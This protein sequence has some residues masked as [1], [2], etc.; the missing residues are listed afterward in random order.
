M[1]KEGGWEDRP[2][3]VDRFGR[4]WAVRGGDPEPSGG[5]DEGQV[6]DQAQEAE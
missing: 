5:D 4:E 6:G 3:G 2:I 1:V